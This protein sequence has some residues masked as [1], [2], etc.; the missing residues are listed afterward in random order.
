MN[1][2][3]SLI[4]PCET[5]VREFDAKLLLACHAA[6]RGWRVF[7]GSKR[8]LDFQAAQIPLGTYVGKSL[9]Y[10]NAHF[11]RIVCNLGHR[12]TAWDEEGLVYANPD[13][14]R[15]TKIGDVTLNMPQ[16]LLTWGEENAAALSA[17]PSFGGPDLA[18]TGNPRTDLLRPELRGFFSAEAQALREEFGDFLLINTNFSR[19]NHFFDQQNRQQ[20]LLRDGG[21]AVT[22][23]ED[24]RIGLAAH[25][26]ALFEHFQ[27]MVPELARCFPDL[28]IVIRPHPSENADLWHR[29]A[30]EHSHVQVVHRGNIAAWLQ[31]AMA[32]VHNGCTTAVESYLL[33]RPAIAYRPVV[34]EDFDFDLP[35]SLSVQAFDCD[36][37]FTAVEK[38][39]AGQRC[40][41]DALLACRRNRIRRHIASVDGPM[42][43]ERILDA[44]EPVAAA[45]PPAVDPV[46]RAG[47]VIHA[48]ARR[49]TRKALEVL[50]LSKQHPKYRARIFP[51][52]EIAEVENAVARFGELLQR[53]D[54]VK[55]RPFAESAFELAAD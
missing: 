33:D 22:T 12:L 31:A 14:Y 11:Y 51:D 27:R 50:P 7:V 35:N 29:I 28:P 2:N 16:L 34:S 15:L 19:L 38:V 26:A 3:P 23:A 32:T 24:P 54:G 48:G 17:H 4:L 37:L 45:P 1:S 41:F 10:R 49:A 53:F 46:A 36:S 30:A 20:R 8:S 5:R 52:V 6:E 40:E 21:A 9:T 39:R 18:I 55:V 44:L 25:K 42:A 47:A 43:C 13:L